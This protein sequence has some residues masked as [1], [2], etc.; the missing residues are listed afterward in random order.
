LGHGHAPLAKLWAFSS[1]IQLKDW[2]DDEDKEILESI[3]YAENKLG[4]KMRTP[5]VLPKEHAHAPIKYDIE[6]LSQ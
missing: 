3:K 1:L 2:D 5:K 6:D 4:S